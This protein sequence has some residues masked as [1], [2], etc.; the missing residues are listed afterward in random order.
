M[1]PDPAPHDF[2]FSDEPDLSH[3]VE[4]PAEA[5]D[6]RETVNVGPDSASPGTS[7]IDNV[8]FRWH[9]KELNDSEFVPPLIVSML[10]ALLDKLQEAKDLGNREANTPI[11]DFLTDDFDEEGLLVD[12]PM[13]HFMYGSPQIG[14]Q[15]P[16]DMFPESTFPKNP[17]DGPFEEAF[18]ETDPV[19][20]AVRPTTSADTSTAVTPPLPPVIQGEEGLSSRLHVLVKELLSDNDPEKIV[21]CIEVCSFFSFVNAM[22]GKLINGGLFLHQFKPFLDSR[23]NSIRDAGYLDLAKAIVD[24][25]DCLEHELQMLHEL[26]DAGASSFIAAYLDTRLQT[27]RNTRILA[28]FEIQAQRDRVDRITANLAVRSSSL[29]NLDLSIASCETKIEQFRRGLR[30]EE[31]T[32]SILQMTKVRVYM[33]QP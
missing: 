10:L 15:M 14:A 4:K 28:E 25:L 17:E 22:I 7:T 16:E 18:V 27:W 9:T 24:D 3:Q 23:I 12:T 33:G 2:V 32:L 26:Q 19:E 1:S 13:L 5:A 29:D 30:E 21:I 8:L 11:R 31:E 6:V 20:P